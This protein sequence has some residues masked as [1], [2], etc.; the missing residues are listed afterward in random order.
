MNGI[1]NVYKE[2]GWTSHDVVAKLRGILKMKKIGHTGTLDPDA[3]GVLPVCL[4]KATK[5]CELLAGEDKTYETVLR[6]GI[7]TDT[8][9]ISGTVIKETN[10]AVTEKEAISCIRSFEGEYM[11]VPPMY[12][13]LKIN[14]KKLYELA[15]EGKTVERKARPVH[16]YRI[17]IL[18]T[19]LPEIRFSVTCS[20]GTYIR[21]LCHDIG[22]KLGCGACMKSLVRT[23]VGRFDV[24]DSRTLEQ[25]Q[26]L[27]DCGRV[28]EAILPLDQ[29]FDRDPAVVAGSSLQKRVYNGNS[30][31][32]RDLPRPVPGLKDGCRV[33]VYDGGG[34]F[35]GLYR[36]REKEDEFRLV[37]MFRDGGGQG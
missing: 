5:L 14:G 17:E 29:M 36:Y 32:G 20:K 34:A 1:I 25:I 26:K 23:R 13:A 24:K 21:T 8:Q 28:Q 30:F 35:V 31:Y 2:A 11:Q 3:T 22:E 18:K 37:K 4:G 7:T 16:F 19:D 6:L 10:P 9:D 33:R 27:A 12:S 15:R